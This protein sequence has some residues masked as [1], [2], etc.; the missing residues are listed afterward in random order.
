MFGPKTPEVDGVSGATP[1]AKNEPI[2]FE[3]KPFNPMDTFIKQPVAVS[4]N[5]RVHI[6]NIQRF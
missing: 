5:T 4:D 1:P 2:K 3:P 6:P